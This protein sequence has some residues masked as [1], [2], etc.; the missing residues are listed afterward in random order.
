MSGPWWTFSGTINCLFLFRTDRRIFSICSHNIVFS[1]NSKRLGM[2]R[3]VTQSMLVFGTRPETIKMC[4]LVVELKK[5]DSAHWQ[6]DGQHQQMLD[7]VLETFNRDAVILD[8]PARIEEAFTGTMA[9]TVRTT[10]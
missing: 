9:T 3:L 1:K 2:E 4:P 5:G 7:P 6:R 8:Q 10:T